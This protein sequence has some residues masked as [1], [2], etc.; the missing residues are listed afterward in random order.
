GRGLDRR[1]RLLRSGGGFV[2]AQGERDGD[3]RGA[4]EAK[5]GTPSDLAICHRPHTMCS[6]AR[7]E[8]ARI[9]QVMFL[10]ALLTN[11]PL[12]ATKRFLQSWAW[13][14]SLRTD[15]RGLVPMR[16]VPAS[17]MISPPSLRPYSRSRSGSL[18]IPLPP[19]ASMISAEA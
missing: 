9:V 11:G 2:R 6:R 19:M 18:P 16:V 14:H 10:C 1:G 7:M 4:D 8:R 12:S 15:V 5:G 17:W 13:H 3:G